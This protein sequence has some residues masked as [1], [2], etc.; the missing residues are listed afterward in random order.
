MDSG[1]VCHD[2]RNA[3]MARILIVD[4]EPAIRSSLTAIL[5]PEGFHI[6]TAGDG[7]KAMAICSAEPFDLVL[8]DV[9]MPAMDGLAGCSISCAR[10]IHSCGGCGRFVWVR[11]G[12]WI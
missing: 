11:A 3:V 7:A 2:S 5:A 10:C 4:D 9:P 12:R 8:S 6:Q 1:V